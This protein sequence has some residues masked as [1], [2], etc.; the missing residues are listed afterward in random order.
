M[1]GETKI[2]LGEVRH[3]NPGIDPAFDDMLETPDRAVVVSTV[4]R[5]T[6]IQAL[7]PTARTRV[8]IWTNHPTEPDEVIIGLG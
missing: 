2:T 7:V 6:L 4:E 1:D 3:V 8:R 5:V